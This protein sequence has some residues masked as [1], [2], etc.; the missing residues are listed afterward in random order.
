MDA[1]PGN[2]RPPT[3]SLIGRDS[4]LADVASALKAAPAGDTDR[5]RR[6]REDPARVGGGCAVG[7][8]FPDG[9]WV[10]ELAAVGDPA[11]VPDA[12]ASVL[13]VIQQPGMTLVES[14][15]RGI[16]GAVEA[17]CA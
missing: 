10:I 16:G 11:A 9:V 6:R 2:L 12:V 5:R 4:E 17:A 3:T 8:D 13:G 14:V 1:T 15:N 7:T